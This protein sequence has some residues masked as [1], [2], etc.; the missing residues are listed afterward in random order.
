MFTYYQLDRAFE[1][2][3]KL[4]TLF[5]LYIMQRNELKKQIVVE[6]FKNLYKL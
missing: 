1:T 6:F 3:Q 5:S 2:L 4:I